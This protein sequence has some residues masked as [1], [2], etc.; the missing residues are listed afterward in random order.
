MD[1]SEREALEEVLAESQS[2][3]EA[4]A[5]AFD[6]QQLLET[7]E[8][9]EAGIS[10]AQ[11]AVPPADAARSHRWFQHAAWLALGAAASWLVIAV[12]SQFAESLSHRARPVATPQTG[13]DNWSKLGTAWNE[14]RIRWRTEMDALAAESLHSTWPR[15]IASEGEEAYGDN[16]PAPADNLDATA[17]LGDVSAPDWMVAALELSDQDP[18]RPTSEDDGGI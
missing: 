3:R 7:A 2:A 1:D 9:S 15:T 8:T 6:L 10:A 14:T 13:Q 18:E 17:D 4:V 5:E 16:P 11:A 12:G